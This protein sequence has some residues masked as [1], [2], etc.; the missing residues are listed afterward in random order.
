MTLQVACPAKLNLFLAV[1]PRDDIGYH[2]IRSVFQA[3]GLCDEVTIDLTAPSTGVNFSEKRYREQNTVTKALRL[4][5]EFTDLP[6]MGIEIVK[7]IPSQAGLGGGS[8][9]AAAVIRAVRS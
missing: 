1:G 8:A 6:K 2:P 4:M 5:S 9:N 3:V 7:N